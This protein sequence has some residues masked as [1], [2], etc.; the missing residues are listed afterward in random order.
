M[1]ETIAQLLLG[2]EPGDV[3]IAWFGAEGLLTLTYRELRDDIERLA[4][5][6]RTARLSERDRV[7]ILLPNG[8]E[9][10]IVFL[11]V[12]HCAVAAP[13]NPALRAQ[14]L[15]SYMAGLGVGAVIFG[16]APRIETPASTA[17][18]SLQGTPGNLALAR[19]GV[20]LAAGSPV[21]SP[22]HATALVLQT[23]GTTARPKIVPLT[24]A[25]LTASARN[26]GATL[27]LSAADR[28]LNV[29]PLF[30]IHGLVAALLASLGAGGSVVCTSGFDGF[31]FF[32]QLRSS[33]PSWYT[34]VPT[35]H[36]LVAERAPRSA[37]SL[38]DAALRFVR[39]SSAA[40]PTTVMEAIERESGAPVIE[41][42]GMTEAAHQV[43]SNP[44]PPGVRKPTSVGPGGVV[45]V[46]VL[47]AGR[48]ARGEIAVRG[49][50]VFAGYED[51]PE[52]NGASF[53]EGWF[54]TGDEG[55]IDDDGYVFLTGR[56]KEL[57]NRGGE[58]V[59]PAEVED[60]LLRHPAIAQAVVFAM[61]HPRLG[62]EVGAALVVVSGATVTEQEVRA[63]VASALA[64]FKVPRK[65]VFLDALPKGPTGKLQ[66][67]GLAGRLGLTGTTGSD[68]SPELDDGS[69]C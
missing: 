28:C 60:V 67:I 17:R 69:V 1:T 65:V 47:D 37:G 29:M 46:T 57:I 6:M 61:P 49:P 4:G 3:A 11:A 55:Y 44:L 18:L 7:A 27:S 66:R 16:D 36:Q 25:N 19:G 15:E 35:I 54:R 56:L 38:R 58:K 9:A 34:A 41:A 39:S 40:L 26:V 50:N 45:E 68:G 63:H 20:R 33:G 14:E 62:E 12:A 59:A 32:E 51:N 43:C 52:A 8:P 30:H 31:A 21:A 24:Q 5:Q 10:A 22:A 48:D 64:E 13:L 42:Y 23:S 53:T 2:G